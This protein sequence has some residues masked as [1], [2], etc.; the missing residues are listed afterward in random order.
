MSA[1]MSDM[2]ADECRKRICGGGIGRIAWCVRG[3]PRICPVNFT[4]VGDDIV[5]RTAPYTELGMHVAGQAVAFEVDGIDAEAR[6]G[7]SVVV[8]AEATAV[9]DPDELMRL[10]RLGPQPW[11]AGQRVLFVRLRPRAIS[12]RQVGAP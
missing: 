7:W 6:C 2:S 10:R 8:E 11:A 3:K 9:D 5:F 12:G 4:V 1:L